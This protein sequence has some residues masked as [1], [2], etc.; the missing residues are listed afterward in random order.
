MISNFIIFRLKKIKGEKR[1]SRKIL[2]NEVL[3]TD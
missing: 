3:T 2:L 1:K